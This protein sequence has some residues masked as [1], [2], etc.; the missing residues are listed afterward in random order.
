MKMLFNEILALAGRDQ[1]IL[2][3]LIKLGH[4]DSLM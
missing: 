2:L 4:R 3:V 1:N